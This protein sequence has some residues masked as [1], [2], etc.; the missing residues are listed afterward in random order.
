MLREGGWGG[1]RGVAAT[2]RSSEG[3]ADAQTRV[4]LACPSQRQPCSLRDTDRLHATR[5]KTRLN[6]IFL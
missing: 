1:P 2:Q 6:F 4:W 5:R 3:A